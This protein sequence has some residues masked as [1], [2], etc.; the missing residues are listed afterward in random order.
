MSI[1]ELELP[2]QNL[3][4]LLSKTD[5][6]WQLEVKRVL[7]RESLSYADFMIMYALLYLRQ[8]K[9]REIVEF[10]QM[11]KMT[12]SKSLAKLEKKEIVKRVKDKQDSRARVVT[13]TP[14][15]SVVAKNAV[16]QIKKLKEEFFGVLQDN[17]KSALVLLL[18]KLIKDG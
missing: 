14:K 13:L 10:C 12:L 17:S 1:D 4:F 2:E 11:D 5:S 3:G 16:L 18:K 6:V 15:G 8:S 7:R 9:Q